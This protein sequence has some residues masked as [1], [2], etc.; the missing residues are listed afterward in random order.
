[1][2]EI[3]DMMIEAMQNGGVTDG[4]VILDTETGEVLGFEGDE[5]EEEKFD[6]K[7][8]HRERMD[9]YV[10]RLTEC[11]FKVQRFDDYHIRVNDV[12]DVWKGKKGTRSQA[13]GGKMQHSK[14]PNHGVLN[15]VY[16]FFHYNPSK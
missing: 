15:T 3:A 5:I 11:G 4:G 16:K 8:Y 1:M 2:G 12:L 6:W 14:D 7:K 13:K 10:E 9:R